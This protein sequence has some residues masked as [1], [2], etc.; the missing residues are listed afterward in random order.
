MDQLTIRQTSAEL[1]RFDAE[2]ALEPVALPDAR[3]RLLTGFESG[4]ATVDAWELAG[5]HLLNGRIRGLR[6]GTA[7]IAATRMDSVEITGCDLSS[8]RWQGGK[9]SRVRF[10]DCRFL[11][12]KIQTV[13]MEHVVFSGCKL[14]YAAFGQ[15][16][17]S[18]PVVFAGCSLREAEFTGCALAAAAFDGCDL[19]LAT[20]GPGY[21]RGCD[22]RGND[23]SALLGAAHLKQIV[24]DPAQTAQLGEALVAE[25]KITFGGDA[26]GRP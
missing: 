3:S 14:D 21:Y 7:S 18:G 20:F 1:P 26:G 2:T 25:L 17:A 6:A 8:L 10:S 24:I 22:L 15:I 9:I 19:R 4:D 5:A 11:A 23:L 13:A 12:A 16:R